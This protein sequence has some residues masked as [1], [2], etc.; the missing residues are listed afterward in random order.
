MSDAWQ[1]SPHRDGPNGVGGPDGTTA[2]QDPGRLQH[3]PSRHPH[4]P[5]HTAPH[6]GITGERRAVKI[7]CVIWAGGRRKR[8]RPGHLAD[9][10]PV[11]CGTGSP[12]RWRPSWRTPVAG[13]PPSRPTRP[14]TTS[15]GSGGGD[16]PIDARTRARHEAV[17]HLLDQGVGLLECTRRLGWGLNTVKRYARAARVEDLIRPRRFRATLVDPYCDYLRCRLIAD[18]DVPVTHLPA[19]IRSQ[20][21]PG[22]ANLLVRYL[23]QGRA[24]TATIPPAPRRLTSWIMTRPHDLTDTQRH[25][26]DEI[27]GLCPHLQTL[28]DRVRQFA[29]LLTDRRGSDLQARTTTVEADELPAA[30]S[31]V[32]GLRLEHDAVVAGLTL[33]YSNGPMEG[34]D[35]KAKLLK[36]QMYGR[37]GFPL[38]RQRILLA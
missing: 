25:D 21:Y 34:T 8:T 24:D 30:H 17:H 12:K 7:A 20:G 29:D 1:T 19:E 6:A 22:S 33:P 27:L 31:F 37:A 28:T 5:T 35:T 18:P 3:L 32:Q 23:K 2:T 10:P 4:R 13:T 14:G 15:D 11:P 9:G 38:L 26:L 16:C 36:R